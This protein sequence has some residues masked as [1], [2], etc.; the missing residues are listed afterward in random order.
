MPIVFHLKTKTVACNTNENA[1][2]HFTAQHIAK[3]HQPSRKPK[4]GKECVCPT[5]P[6]T[7][8]SYYRQE[9]Q[10]LTVIWRNDGL[11]ASYDGFV[12]NSSA[13]LR[14]HFCAKN[15]PLRQAAIRCMSLHSFPY[16]ALR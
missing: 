15:P 13:V 1:Q 9:G 10:Q 11:S 2:G 6:K 8:K 5:A 4:L 14:L 16:Q 12:V 7:A 3:S